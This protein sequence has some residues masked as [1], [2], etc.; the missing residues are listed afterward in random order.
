MKII[1]LIIAIL[2]SLHAKDTIKV[3]TEHLPP[4][5]VAEDSVVKSGLSYDLVTEMTRRT[6]DEYVMKAYL[7]EHAYSLALKKEN[8][9]I[10]SMIRSD[11]REAKFKWVGKIFD[12]DSYFWKLKSNNSIQVNTLEDVKNY[13]IG[14]S[15]EDNQHQSLLQ[16]GFIEGENLYSTTYWDQAIKM[17]FLG[18]I[19]MIV[20][21]EVML[22][23]KLKDLK[24]DMVK[25]E[26]V[27]ARRKKTKGLY[28]AFSNMT[29]DTIVTRYK[30]AY[31]S[32]ID[33]GTFD[34]I[35]KKYLLP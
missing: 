29:S 12:V 3:V 19:D 22:S 16:D 23:A 20:G 2:C 27:M 10:Y 18:R 32:M 8:V 21:P 7:W 6:G 4:F 24:Y 15:S 1:I 28:F 34:T 25:L 9:M 30:K 17:L 33:D 31:Q 11:E 26:K 14:V 35:L 5:Q 13:K